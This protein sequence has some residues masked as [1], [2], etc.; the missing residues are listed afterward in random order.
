MLPSA[1]YYA[2]SQSIQSQTILGVQGPPRLDMRKSKGHAPRV[3]LGGPR[4]A[5]PEDNRTTSFV[6]D[7]FV[8]ASVG[9][10]YVM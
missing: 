9:Y 2:N 4:A 3:C 7:A 1:P 8:D 5:H 10:E 6:E